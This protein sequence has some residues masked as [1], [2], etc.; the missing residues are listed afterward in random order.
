MRT[1]TTKELRPGKEEERQ[2]LSEL[3]AFEEALCRLS[4]KREQQSQFLMD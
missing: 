4:E 1:R 3:K 2:C